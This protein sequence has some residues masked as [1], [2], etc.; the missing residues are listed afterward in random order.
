MLLNPFP[1]FSV[2]SCVLQCAEFPHTPVHHTLH[3]VRSLWL[4]LQ[5]FLSQSTTKLH[6]FFET[7]SKNVAIFC[8]SEATTCKNV[9]P[10][11]RFHRGPPVPPPA[12]HPH[13]PGGGAGFAAWPRPPVHR[14]GPVYWHMTHCIGQSYQG[15]VLVIWASDWPGPFDIILNTTIVVRT[16]VV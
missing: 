6:L 16:Y 4:L 13:Q 11:G 2:S 12:G 7:W 10:A 9:P 1:T 5:V 14:S 3:T 8:S 15:P